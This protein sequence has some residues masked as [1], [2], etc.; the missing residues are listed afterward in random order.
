[1]KKLKILALI[2]ALVNPALSF[3]ENNKIPGI[4]ISDSAVAIP[5]PIGTFASPVSVLNYDP[6]VDLQERNLTEG[7]ADIAIRG[8]TFEGTGLRIGAIGI[9]D[10]QTGHYLAEVP[11]SPLMLSQ[12]DVL[13][14]LIILSM[15]LMLPQAQS[16]M[17]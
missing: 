11:F 7:Q 3:A 14:G 17:A 13:T 4:T 16:A 8:G 12:P 6:R 1:M 2:V 10:P 5:D 9:F 15:D